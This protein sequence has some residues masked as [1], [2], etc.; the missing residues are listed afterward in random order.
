MFPRSGELFGPAP[1]AMAT[2]HGDSDTGIG[3]YQMK[4]GYSAGFASPLEE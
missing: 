4:R 2:L 1:A 3:S